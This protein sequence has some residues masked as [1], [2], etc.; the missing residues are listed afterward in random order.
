MTP[1]S[2]GLD[3]DLSHVSFV[4][5]EIVEGASIKKNLFIIQ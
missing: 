2:Y 1:D 4:N 5:E 3:M